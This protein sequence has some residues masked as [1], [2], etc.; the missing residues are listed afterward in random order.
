MTVINLKNT[1]SNLGNNAAFGPSGEPY[2]E[3]ELQVIESQ[4]SRTAETAAPAE[5]ADI[6]LQV[7]EVLQSPELQR[8][9]LIPPA[10]EQLADIAREVIDKT[11]SDVRLVAQRGASQLADQFERHLKLL[12]TQGDSLSDAELEDLIAQT[13][14]LASS[15]AVPAEFYQLAQ[16]RLG[17]LELNGPQRERLNDYLARRDVAVNPGTSDN[18]EYVAEAD[19]LPVSVVA[20]N[21][22]MK[23]EPSIPIAGQVMNL[24]R[25]D[26]ALSQDQA[27]ERLRDV[28]DTLLPLYPADWS[29]GIGGLELAA[30][31]QAVLYGDATTPDTQRSHADEL[32]SALEAVNASYPDRMRRRHPT[33]VGFLA[34][35]AYVPPSSSYWADALSL[36]PLGDEAI[37]RAVALRTRVFDTV[38]TFD[39]DG[40]I[41]PSTFDAMAKATFNTSNN[42]DAAGIVVDAEELEAVRRVVDANAE[43]QSPPFRSIESYLKDA[44]LAQRFRLATADGEEVAPFAGIGESILNE[45]E[46]GFRDGSYPTSRFRH[47]EMAFEALAR[48]IEAVEPEDG[49]QMFLDYTEA[50]RNGFSIVA[51]APNRLQFDDDRYYPPS[52]QLNRYKRLIAQ[53]YLQGDSRGDVA[54]VRF[55]QPSAMQWVR[56]TPLEEVATWLEQGVVA[57]DGG[58]AHSFFTSVVSDL[59]AHT[60]DGRLEYTPAESRRLLSVLSDA[61]SPSAVGSYQQAL[62]PLMYADTNEDAYRTRFQDFVG[63]TFGENNGR[64]RRER[65]LSYI[66]ARIAEPLDPDDQYRQYTPLDDEARRRLARELQYVQDNLREP[67]LPR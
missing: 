39:V 31:H 62:I 20:Q 13:D 58:R 45:L 47:P 46:S 44:D 49:D 23:L 48:V 19:G 25:A 51:N 42:P 9:E 59:V 15:S 2:D 10:K 1:I 57:R 4:A 65:M 66:E 43:A 27:L 61:L 26:E 24:I 38:F 12:R 34:R 21:A 53:L 52:Q 30:L 29:E 5:R 7:R 54:R 64:E 14:E 16:G 6:A 40:P 17:Q 32:I 8:P 67:S 41:L 35:P 33:E 56:N 60:G 36:D 18:L 55:S 50:Q 11:A 28:A 22:Y 37:A 3:A 63:D